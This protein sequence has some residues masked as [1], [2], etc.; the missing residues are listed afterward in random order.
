M[1]FTVC[2]CKPVIIST[3]QVC[4]ARM[5]SPPRLPMVTSW[6]PNWSKRAIYS[7]SSL[8]STWTPLEQCQKTVLNLQWL[9]SWFL[10]SAYKQIRQLENKQIKAQ[11]AFYIADL[12]WSLKDEF[13]KLISISIPSHLL[14]WDTAS[15]TFICT[16]RCS[17]K[18]DQLSQKDMS[19]RS[20]H[21]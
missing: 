16:T 20:I 19:V 21:L 14:F 17:W 1:T 6:Y 4:A 7:K 5:S 15:S 18:E 9:T 3:S 8:H 12:N 2:T 13:S 11:V 10:S